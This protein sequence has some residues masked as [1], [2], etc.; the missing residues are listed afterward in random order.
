MDKAQQLAAKR[1]VRTAFYI[2][3]K[4]CEQVRQAVFE[5]YNVWYT[6]DFTQYVLSKMHW[7]GKQEVT[8]FVKRLCVRLYCSDISKELICK[9]LKEKYGYS[10]DFSAIRT[11]VAQYNNSHP[12][13]KALRRKGFRYWDDATKKDIVDRYLSGELRWWIAKSYKCAI[14][15]ITRVL[16]EYGVEIRSYQSEMDRIAPYSNFSLEKIDSHLKAYFL[17]LLMTDGNIIHSN[18]FVVRLTTKDEDLARF[19][20]ERTGMYCIQEVKRGGHTLPTGQICRGGVYYTIAAFSKRIYN[21]ALRFG[22]TPN[23]TFTL[24]PIGFLEEEEKFF[25]YILRGI[26]DG[27]GWINK[28]KNGKRISFGVCNASYNFI[29]W[30]KNIL[31]KIGMKNISL[32][33]RRTE[34]Y[35][36][37]YLL[38][39]SGQENI[40]VLRDKVY[41]VP[42]GM[43]RKYNI[44]HSMEE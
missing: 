44:L 40:Q 31:E 15:T 9:T 14:P 8:D 37:I 2:G 1:I 17:G 3:R 41:D 20:A 36:D 33:T 5:R 26:I 25:P 43:S 6:C 30:C 12:E 22:I 19:L 13:N 4:R 28:R 21:E 23:K 34:G 39:S 10:R 16:N 42:F 27:D 7:R 24:N 35:S 29:V 11:F 18:N 32:Y 38:Y